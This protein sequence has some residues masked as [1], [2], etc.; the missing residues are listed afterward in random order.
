MP[1]SVSLSWFP[2]SSQ[3]VVGWYTWNQFC[4]DHR[5][6]F[7]WLEGNTERRRFVISFLSLSHSQCG[8]FGVS[9][10]MKPD[11]VRIR[12]SS[13]FFTLFNTQFFFFFFYFPCFR[14]N[15]EKKREGEKQNS[16]QLGYFVILVMF[17]RMRVSE[18]VYTIQNS[19]SLFVDYNCCHYSW[20]KG[21]DFFD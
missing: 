11:C 16:T 18:N 9:W 10:N 2:K 6:L 8:C 14:L 7:S 3:R 4:S 1:L 15:P 20:E 21:K 13:S 17:G 19:F 12:P 5:A